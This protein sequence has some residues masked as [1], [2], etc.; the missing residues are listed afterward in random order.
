M[1]IILVVI[2]KSPAGN[3]VNI[4]NQFNRKETFLTSLQGEK[5][6][7]KFNPYITE[8]LFSYC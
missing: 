3:T 6:V 8:I 7:Q 4:G 5:T 2:K 1:E